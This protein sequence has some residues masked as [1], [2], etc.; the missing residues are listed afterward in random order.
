M[1]RLLRR[2]AGC[3]GLLLLVLSLGACEQEDDAL[4]TLQTDIPF[5]ADG[6]L[7][8][9]T[10]GDSLITRIAIEIAE[11]DS[12]RTRGL[13]ERRGLPAR[14]GML[15]L[16][17]E[18]DRR[19]FWMANTPLPLDLIFVAPDGEIVNIVK[20][21]RPYS[22]DHIQSTAPAQYVVEVRAGFT[23]RYGITDEARIRWQ[24]SE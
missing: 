6:A 18:P 12:A 11:T 9:L 3:C 4:P 8:F 7:A 5:R 22:R 17:D 10:P 15:F 24:R 16:F 23:D 13:M 20:R 14:G 2:S 1:L 19:S 21:T